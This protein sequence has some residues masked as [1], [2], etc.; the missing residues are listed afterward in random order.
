MIMASASEV[1]PGA[2]SEIIILYD[3]GQYS[4]IWGC[5]RN[6]QRH[7]DL[8]VRWNGNPG[9]LGY[10]NSRGYPQ[11]YVEHP[12]LHEAVLLGLQTKLMTAEKSQTNSRYLSNIEKAL[13]E[14]RLQSGAV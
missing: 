13:S 7:K 1:V 6:E 14:A 11:W 5:L 2:W 10:P 4:A 12:F 9:E 3:D 8:G